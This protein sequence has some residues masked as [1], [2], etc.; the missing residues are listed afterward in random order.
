[1]NTGNDQAWVNILGGKPY[2]MGVAPW[3]L[4]FPLPV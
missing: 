2:M 4:S 3:Y 1:M